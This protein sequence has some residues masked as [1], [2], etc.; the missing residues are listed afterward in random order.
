MTP[1]YRRSC[2]DPH[3]PGWVIATECSRTVVLTLLM[4]TVGSVEMSE[5][6]RRHA[7]KN[8]RILKNAAVRT[9][10]LARINS[11][12]KLYFFI[13]NFSLISC[14]LHSWHF[15]L[16]LSVFPMFSAIWKT[17]IRLLSPSFCS[18]CFVIRIFFSFSCLLDTSFFLTFIS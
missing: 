15:S 5:T 8:T 2:N 7:P 9:S 18:F 1:S 12:K 3:H 16:S 11:L 10:N 6:T 13:C 14:F 4:K 17:Q